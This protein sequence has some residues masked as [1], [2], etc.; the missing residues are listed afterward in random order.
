MNHAAVLQIIAEYLDGLL[1]RQEAGVDL[2]S[3]EVATQCL[4]EAAGDDGSVPAS[5]EAMGTSLTKVLE[6]AMPQESDEFKL[7]LTKL[8]DSGFFQGAEKGSDEYQRRM[9][10][11]QEKWTERKQKK[12]TPVAEA[13]D[14]EDL[15]KAGNAK[16]SAGE[17]DEA[18][19]LY[20]KAIQVDP[21]NA[22]YFANRA[23]AHMKLQNYSAAVSDSREAVRI[24]RN[25]VKGHYRLGLALEGE[26][27]V[28]EAV[29]VLEEALKVD[30]SQGGSLSASIQEQI[31]RMQPP[32]SQGFDLNSI[33]QNPMMQNMMQNPDLMKSM[34]QGFGGGASGDQSGAPA[35]LADMMNKPEVQDLKEDPE[36]A[37]AMRDVQENGMGAAMKYLSNPAIMSKIQAAFG[38]Q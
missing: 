12:S 4:R 18:I 5:L 29:L 36:L 24:D 35:G 7:F 1:A 8:T 20:T 10:K 14:A 3:I 33:L 28:D 19:A 9:A 31:N 30:K 37:E 32:A 25:Y 17:F 22:V 11:V 6:A 13:A 38:K 34:M 27:H 16:L 23:A 21:N 26:S 2:E 15:K